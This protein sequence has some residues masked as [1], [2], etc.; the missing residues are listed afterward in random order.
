[1][2]AYVHVHTCTH[3]IRMSVEKCLALVKVEK[4]AWKCTVTSNMDLLN[5]ISMMLLNIHNALCQV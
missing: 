4:P 3:V 2:H 1:M 5:Y